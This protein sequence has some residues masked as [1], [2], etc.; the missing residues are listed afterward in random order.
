MIRASFA[1]G[2]LTP[3][4]SYL[5]L[6]DD[7]QK[8]ALLAKQRQTVGAHGDLDTDESS[9]EQMPE[10]GWVPLLGLMSLLL[11]L[12]TRNGWNKTRRELS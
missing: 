7:A 9:F 8:Q 1:S 5:A 12:G 6:E 3:L 10:P 11:A 2:I 4:T